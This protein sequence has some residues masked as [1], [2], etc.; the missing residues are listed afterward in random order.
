[1]FDY[2]NFAMLVC[3]CSMCSVNQL[4]FEYKN[5]FPTQIHDFIQIATKVF[6]TKCNR[7]SMKLVVSTSMFNQ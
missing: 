1:M 4:Y 5:F 6:L 2:A 7:T 3:I